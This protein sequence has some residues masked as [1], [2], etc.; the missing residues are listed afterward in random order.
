MFWY[1]AQNR[2]W[3]LE[4]L[5]KRPFR[6]D[7]GELTIEEVNNLLDRLSTVSKEYVSDLQQFTNLVYRKDQQP[8]LTQFYRAMNPTELKWLIRIILRRTVVAKLVPNL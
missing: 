5:S 8:I 6:D 7:F 3:R 4:I 1:P 2:S